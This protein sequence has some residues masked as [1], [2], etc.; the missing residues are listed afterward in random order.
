MMKLRRRIPGEDLPFEPT[1][2]ARWGE[3]QRKLDARCGGYM[4]VNMAGFVKC[5]LQEFTE[6]EARVRQVK[7]WG[8]GPVKAGCFKGWLRRLAWCVVRLPACHS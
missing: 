3:R 4:I 6:H 2:T 5:F 7:Q 1:L 8:A